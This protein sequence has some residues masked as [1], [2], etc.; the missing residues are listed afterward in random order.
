MALELTLKERAQ[1]AGKLLLS[2]DDPTEAEVERLWI[3]EA[4]RRLEEFRAGRVK[5]IPAE[6][7]FR[8]L[9]AAI[10]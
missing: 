3:A 6:K 1:L 2:I 10:K 9:K 5:S 7:V 8:R 4:E